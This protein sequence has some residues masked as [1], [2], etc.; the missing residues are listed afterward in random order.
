LE[1][2]FDAVYDFTSIEAV[3]NWLATRLPYEPEANITD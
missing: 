3:Q 1:Q 2:L